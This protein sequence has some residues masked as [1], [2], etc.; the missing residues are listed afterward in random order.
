MAKKHGSRGYIEVGTTEVGQRVSFN[1]DITAQELEANTQGVDWTGVESG[2]LSAK[3]SIEVFYD[4]ADT[5]QDLIVVG[6]KVSLKLYPSGDSAT[7]EEISGS[8]LITSASL[9]SAANE[10]IKR[11]YDFVNDGTVTTTTLS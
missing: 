5:G 7:N 10:L 3:G 11:T 4:P 1:V 8:F 9:P 2:L 6:T